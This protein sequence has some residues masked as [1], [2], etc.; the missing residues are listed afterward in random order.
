[1][2]KVNNKEKTPMSSSRCYFTRCSSVSIVKL[3]HVIAGLEAL[4][5]TF[6]EKRQSDLLQVLLKTQLSYCTK[7]EVC[8]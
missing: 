8:H 3:E 1:M 5:K 7:N 6:K 2:F 4:E